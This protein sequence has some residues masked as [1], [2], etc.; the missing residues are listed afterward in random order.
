MRDGCSNNRLPVGDGHNGP[1]AVV[2][3]TR[4]PSRDLPPRPRPHERLSMPIRM[5]GAHPRHPAPGPARHHTL[6]PVFSGPAL[7]RLLFAAGALLLSQCFASKV[8][9]SG[10]GSP[11]LVSSGGTHFVMSGATGLVLDCDLR[12]Y[13]VFT[14]APGSAVVLRGFGSPLL[15]GV[16]SFSNLTM[17]LDGD[18]TLANPA[19]V[20]GALTLIKGRLSLSGHDLAANSI[21]GGAPN[22]YVVTP[23][24]VGRLVRTVGAGADVHFPVGHSAYNPV[25]VRT[26]TGSDVFR[27]AALDDPAATGLDA[28]T[29]LTRAWAV[30]HPNPSG[31]NGSLTMSVQWNANEYGAGFDR[32]LGQPTSAW[33]WRWVNGAWVPQASVRRTDNGAFPA[34]DSLVTPDA[35]V[36]TLAGVSQLLA[37]QPPTAAPRVVEMAPVFPNPSRGAVNVRFGL[38]ASGRVTVALYS[39]LG[40]RV[41]TLADG[42]R[43]AGWH[44]VRLDDARLPA[45]IYFVRLQSGR[46]VRS[47]KL[48]VTR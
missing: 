32:S 24:T 5:L 20:V 33:A 37:A 27:V 1:G 19:T 13:G 14:P 42:E 48:V 16:S 26:G 38:P 35:G 3:I 28:Q 15:F 25:S 17:R 11:G 8:S 23:D 47:S 45:G 2:A 21:F 44:L 4:R 29:A 30:S 40:E 31:V 18:A 39:V 34:V 9:A 43:E 10:P 6:R 12:N 22:S 7:T 36:W 46:V 41:A